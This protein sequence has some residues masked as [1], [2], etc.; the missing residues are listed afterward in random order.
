M[1]Y[2]TPTMLDN[3]MMRHVSLHA[4]LIKGR[5][6]RSYSAHYEVRAARYFWNILFHTVI[7]TNTHNWSQ[8]AAELIHYAG[9]GCLFHKQKLKC[10]EMLHTTDGNTWVSCITFPTPDGSEQAPNSPPK[11][12]WAMVREHKTRSAQSA[13]RNVARQWPTRP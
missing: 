11:E 6:G 10:L 2:C 5:G 7:T 13:E 3:P 12:C 1:Q 9:C 4:I 8:P